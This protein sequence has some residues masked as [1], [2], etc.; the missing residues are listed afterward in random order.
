MSVEAAVTSPNASPPPPP[1]AAPAMP[2]AAAE[3]AAIEKAVA[4]ATGQKSDA[5]ADG[6]TAAEAAKN[7]EPGTEEP[8]PTDRIGRARAKLAER[9]TSLIER[10][11]S[12]RSEADTM[13]QAHQAAMAKADA[14][15]AKAESIV[16]DFKK[17]LFGAIEKYTGIRREDVGARLLNGGNAGES[18][19][20]RAD[21]AAT[22]ALE[23]K[24]AAL[25]TRLEERSSR[26]T[27][28]ATARQEEARFVAEARATRSET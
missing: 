11:A 13:R 14:R 2:D 6:E 25:E 27:S 9:E 18:E 20:A 12:L 5:P 26:D 23:A 21:N 8:A 1:P 17:D 16:D 28:A 15:H 22:T 7:G 10:T 19:K 4:A 24:L 3:L